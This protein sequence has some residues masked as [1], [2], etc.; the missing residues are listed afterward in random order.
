MLRKLLVP[1]IGILIIISIILGYYFIFDNKL[2]VPDSF[3]EA[4]I[5]GAVISNFLNEF[6]TKSI[7]TLNQIEEKDKNNQREEALDM[8]IYE[9][10]RIRV[11]REQTIKLLSELEKMAA[12][13]PDI[14]NT[15]AQALGMQAIST[16]IS[17]IDRLLNYNERMRSLLDILRQ[18][19]T[20]RNPERF[21]AE[22]ATIISALNDDAL[23]I[24]ELNRKYQNLMEEF[25]RRIQ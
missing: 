23:T 6:S 9:L 14:R 24:N 21:N 18:K 4:R 5:N 15:E 8:A 13:I 3:A 16:K 22:M 20:T 11:A 10:E 19:F 25:D 12:S 17:L 7:E 2:P 1:F